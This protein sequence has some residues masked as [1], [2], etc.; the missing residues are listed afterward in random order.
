MAEEYKIDVVK[1]ENS[2]LKNTQLENL[3]FGKVFTDHMLVADYADGKWQ[4]VQI[5]PY[6]PI[7]LDPAATV[8]HY[9]QEIF[10]GIKAFHNAD[11]NDYIFRPDMNWKR[12]NTSAVGLCMPEVPEEIF[13]GGMKKLIETD[14]E[15]IPRM[16]EHS[17]YIR[18]FMIASQAFLGVHPAKEYKFIIILSPSGPYFG[19]PAAIRIER[20]FTRSAKGGV[21]YSKNGGNYAASLKAVE[22]AEA[23]GYDQVLWTAPNDHK[24]IQEVGAMN[25]MFVIDNKVVTPEL[26]GTILAGVTRDSVIAVLHDL[27]ITVEERPISIDELLEAHQTGKLTE[28]FGTGTAAVIS[29]IGKLELSE[30]TIINFDVEKF[31]TGKKLKAALDDLRLGKVA[32]T[33]GWLVKI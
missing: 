25:V 11:G 13:I 3:P 18:P 32:D 5:L 16:A 8:F 6:G 33:H 29:P 23:D 12:F 22:K 4:K 15:W 1:T 24:Y 19:K 9:G 30:D 14:R 31:E 7:T 2:K 10:E 26:D 21:G 20:H 17:L 28:A 27:G